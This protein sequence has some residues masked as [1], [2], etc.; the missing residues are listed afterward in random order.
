ML[1]S[2][3]HKRVSK[4]EKSF[5]YDAS[6][7]HEVIETSR[8]AFLKFTLFQT[9][10]SHREDVPRDAWF[11]AD[12]DAICPLPSA[13]ALNDL[14]GSADKELIVVAGGHVG[15]VVGSRAPKVLYPAMRE[16]LLR[17]LSKNAPGG[18]TAAPPK[19]GKQ[20]EETCN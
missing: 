14:C 6:Y 19:R 5:G 8:P 13:R 17:R 12:R 11:A 9:M 1:K 15:A 16:W 10:S 7:I 2:F 20:Q 4:L 18:T 3:L